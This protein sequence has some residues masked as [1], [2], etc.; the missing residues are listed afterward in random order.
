MH[1]GHEPRYTDPEFE[2][3]GFDFLKPDAVNQAIGSRAAP[4]ALAHT[5]ILSPVV[6]GPPQALQP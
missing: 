5:H 3:V 4:L 1:P 6:S 2:Y